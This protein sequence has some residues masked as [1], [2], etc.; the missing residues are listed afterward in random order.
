MNDHTKKPILHICNSEVYGGAEEHVRTIL[1][2][3]RKL[4]VPVV[5]AVPPHAK[6][7]SVLRD[8]GIPVHP[9]Y[10]GHKADIAGLVS[11]CTLIRKESAALI[12]THNRREDL[13]GGIASLLLGVPAVTTIHDKINM[14]QQGMKVKNVRSEVYHFI[15]RHCFKKLITVSKATY[16]DIQ[17]NARVPEEKIEHIVNGLD[18]DRIKPRKTVAETKKA[19]SIPENTKVVGFV[20]RIRGSSFGKKGIVNL[21]DAAQIIVKTYPRVLFMISG[22]DADAARILKNLCE[23]K[24]VAPYFRFL[25]YRDDIIDLMHCFDLLACPS[26][27]EGLPRVV[28]ECMA[29]GIPV[30]G[31]AVDGIPEVVENDVSGYLVPPREPAVLAEKILTLLT[32]DNRRKTFS[33]NAKKR[34]ETGFRAE[35]SAQRTAHVYQTILSE[36]E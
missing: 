9:L 34:I 7:Y 13:M 35:Y 1:K 3:L 24:R 28:L 6:L 15:L 16:D 29:I 19:L 8:E 14:N 20:A 11:L 30:V 26:L 36:R 27:F 17:R 33:L 5:A 25:G 32:D 4:D 22:E 2:Y 23:E 12:H 21:I 10:I 18:L 31:S